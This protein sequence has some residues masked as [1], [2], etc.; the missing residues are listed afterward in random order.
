M[1]GDG[2]NLG[3][4]FSGKQLYYAINDVKTPRRL[5]R[6]GCFDFNFNVAKAIKSQKKEKFS[7]IYDILGR[8][9]GEFDFQRIHMLTIPSHE[10]WTVVPKL[11]YDQSDEREA[12]LK[13]IMSG[14]KR[15]VIEPTWYELSNRDFKFLSIRN[16]AIMGGYEK[17]AEHASSAEFC[18]DFELGSRWASHSDSKGSFL[19][20]SSYPGVLSIASFMLGKFRGATY[21]EFEDYDDLPYLWLSFSQNIKWMNGLY[22]EILVYG[23]KS[24][25]VIE[26]LQSIWDESSNVVKMDTLGAMKVKAEET[27]YSFNLESAFPAI[28]LS[29]D[30]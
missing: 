1:S 7:G 18:S 8:L 20:I 26:E 5:K 6:I 11:V 23:E 16:K 27:T 29:L 19:T 21:L 12:H 10:C 14:I 2:P 4:C 24:Y 9:K 15:D 17:L 28:L 22:D 3:I 25:K 13:I 30:L